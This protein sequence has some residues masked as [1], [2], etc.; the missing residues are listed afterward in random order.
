LESFT[1]VSNENDAIVNSD[2][3]SSSSDSRRR[4]LAYSTSCFGTNADG[5]YG[6]MVNV[7][8]EKEMTFEIIILNFQINA[9]FAGVIT[10]ITAIMIG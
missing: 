9:G 7:E 6:V 10:R 3:W 8:I 1:V 4:L 5:V 2:S